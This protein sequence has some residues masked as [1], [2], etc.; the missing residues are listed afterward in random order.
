MI[1]DH[2][3]TSEGTVEDQASD[4]VSIAR[5]WIVKVGFVTPV[6][7]TLRSRPLFAQTVGCS[8]WLSATYTSHHAYP[9][10]APPQCKT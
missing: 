2:T 6:I 5:R 9:G 7:L 4:V 1:S 8:A 3:K 10:Q